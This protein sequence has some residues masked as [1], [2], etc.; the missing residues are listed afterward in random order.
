MSEE[1][2]IQEIEELQQILKEDSSNFQARRQLAMIL[3]DKGFT[4]EAL[5]QFQFLISI[6]PNDASLHYNKGIV[7][8]KLRDT[9]NAERAYL[10]AIELSPEETDFY[11]NLGLVYIDM[12][13]YDKGIQ[14]FK[15]VLETDVDDSN[16]FFNLFF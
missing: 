15:T 13:E 8:E 6:F 4:E 12:Q 11:Y 10:K 5:K 2:Y 1:N 9:K 3:L 16:S 7:Y 14:C